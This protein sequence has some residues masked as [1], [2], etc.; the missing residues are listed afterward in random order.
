MNTDKVEK[1]KFRNP[2]NTNWVTFKVSLKRSLPPSSEQI[3]SVEQLDVKAEELIDLIINSYHEA[4]PL[5]VNKE[6]RS[7]SF[8]TSDVKNVR[9]KVR[10]AFIQAKDRNPAKI[11]ARRPLRVFI[12]KLCVEAEELNFNNFQQ[13]LNVVESY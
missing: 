11:E 10:K 2:E 12:I 1:I 6:G 8:F 13:Y 4:C 5:K 9:T 7:A 3:D